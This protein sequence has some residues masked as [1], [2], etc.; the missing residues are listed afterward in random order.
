MMINYQCFVL[1]SSFDQ[2]LKKTVRRFVRK[3]NLYVYRRRFIDID[4]Y[5]QIHMYLS[6]I[7]SY[8]YEIIMMIKLKMRSKVFELEKNGLG[9]HQFCLLQAF[10]AHLWEIL[11]S[12]QRSL[13][14]PQIPVVSC[15]AGRPVRDWWPGMAGSQPGDHRFLW[16]LNSLSH[17]CRMIRFFPT[18]NPTTTHVIVGISWNRWGQQWWCTITIDPGGSWWTMAISA[19]PSAWSH[20]QRHRTSGWTDSGSAVPQRSGGRLRQQGGQIHFVQ[21]QV[22]LVWQVVFNRFL[23]G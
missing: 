3:S 4:R 10:A 6:Y 23:Q 5:L 15:V 21:V 13:L 1:W 20:L 16:G 8:V 9:S 11:G 18:T 17:F 19:N 7:D 22:G 12:P 2:G 14:S